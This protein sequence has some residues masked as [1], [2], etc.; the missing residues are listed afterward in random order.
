MELVGNQLV[1]D[2]RNDGIA[3]F[4]QVR[5]EISD[6]CPAC[7]AGAVRPVCACLRLLV[8]KQMARI[9]VPA[10]IVSTSVAAARLTTSR[11]SFRKT[12]A[13]MIARRRQGHLSRPTGLPGAAAY[14]ST[15]RSPSRPMKR[16]QSKL[17]KSRQVDDR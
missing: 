4:L 2:E 15:S 12:T 10:S 17:H 9:L 11:T 13:S 3:S 8:R 6:T 1:I 5:E 16:N 14:R 7:H